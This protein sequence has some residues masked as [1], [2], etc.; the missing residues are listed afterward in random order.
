MAILGSTAL[1][2][3]RMF[4]RSIHYP[5]SWRRGQG[6]GEP[7]HLQGG[8]VVP[9]LPTLLY[10]LHREWHAKKLPALPSLH[11]REIVSRG[12][13][14]RLQPQGLF[15]AGNRFIQPILPREKHS[16]IDVCHGMRRVHF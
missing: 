1:P 12:F 9:K 15:Q 4:V 6:E 16:Q 11:L 7:L 14:V 13:I 3:Y 5:L 10:K 8:C 2:C